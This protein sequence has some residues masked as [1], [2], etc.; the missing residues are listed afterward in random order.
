[1]KSGERSS[2]E[3]GRRAFLKGLIAS[4]AA[5]AAASAMAPEKVRG[6]QRD[7]HEETLYRETP[8]IRKYYETLRY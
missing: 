7:K 6:K 1:M 2:K 8:E 4:S 3:Y 5:I